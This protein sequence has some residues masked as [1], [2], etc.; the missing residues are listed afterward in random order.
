MKELTVPAAATDAPTKKIQFAEQMAE[1]ILTGR[2]YI[3]QAVFDRIDI[4][5]ADLDKSRDFIAVLH[6]T[7]W[8]HFS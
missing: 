7:T 5:R 4:K 3:L 8:M 1:L 6:T 2:Q